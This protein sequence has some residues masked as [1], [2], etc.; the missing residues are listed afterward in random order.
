MGQLILS[1]GVTGFVFVLAVT[2]CIGGRRQKILW[3]FTKAQNLALIN[4]SATDVF[5][6]RTGAMNWG[7]LLKNNNSLTIIMEIC[8][9]FEIDIVNNV[10]KIIIFKIVGRC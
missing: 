10:Y 7:R 6:D 8:R 9:K 4:V 3:S 1:I 2:N 5:G